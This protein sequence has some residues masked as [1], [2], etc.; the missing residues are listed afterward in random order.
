MTLYQRS[1][2]ALAGLAA[3]EH[4]ESSDEL[5]S[6]G[7]LIAS[8]LDTAR[9]TLQRGAYF[10]KT[11]G[12]VGP[13]ADKKKV[14]KAIAGLEAGLSRFGVKALQHKSTTTAIDAAQELERT[15]ER[16]VGSAWRAHFKDL[17][18][19]ASASTA[20]DLQGPLGAV[21]KVQAA[22]KRLSSAITLNPMTESERLRV[23]FGNDDPAEVIRQIRELASGIESS[24][25][26]LKA[27]HDAMPQSVRSTLAAAHSPAGL[28]LASVTAELLL[29]LHAAGVIDRFVVRTQ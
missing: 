1:L 14:Q 18:V 28:P 2:Q 23:L 12:T 27:D 25:K 22:G 10:A 29:E 7:V 24:M 6:R 26:E 21:M 17:G 3:D 5:L 11:L 20:A 16:W 19:L 4:E 8:Q 9:T 15:V 13:Q